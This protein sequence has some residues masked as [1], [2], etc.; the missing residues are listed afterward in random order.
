MVSVG[1]RYFL[2]AFPYG[3]CKIS[4]L[5]MG[6][7][8]VSTPSDADKQA[9][10]S[11]EGNSLLNLCSYSTACKMLAMSQGCHVLKFSITR[12]NIDLEFS[13]KE[14]RCMASLLKERYF[15]STL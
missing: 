1:V 13:S 5:S 8:F 7:Y 12:E 6:V 3:L 15:R 11:V 9:R 14:N 4:P 10:L 2:D